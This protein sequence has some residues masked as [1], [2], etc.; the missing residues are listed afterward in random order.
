MENEDQK[1]FEKIDW[2]IIAL[3]IIALY[4]IHFFSINSV[5]ISHNLG[6]P[7]GILPLNFGACT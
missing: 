6:N 5:A 1:W 3:I 4:L 7:C 2:I